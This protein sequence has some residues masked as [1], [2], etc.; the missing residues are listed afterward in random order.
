MLPCLTY[1]SVIKLHDN[2]RINQSECK[3]AKQ[4]RGSECCGDDQNTAKSWLKLGKRRTLWSRTWVGTTTFNFNRLA[5]YFLL[6]TVLIKQSP[7]KRQPITTTDPAVWCSCRRSPR[8]PPSLGVTTAAFA[9]PGPGLKGQ[10]RARD[11]LST[12]PSHLQPT[13]PP[14]GLFYQ[15]PIRC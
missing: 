12:Q 15:H 14:P 2:Q 7:I 3:S 10:L 13:T 6:A 9:S 11:S 8:I 5:A 4:P 1:P